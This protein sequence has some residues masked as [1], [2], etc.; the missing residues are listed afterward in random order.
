[1][2]E[3]SIEQSVCRYAKQRGFLVYKFTSPAQRGVPDRLF[4]NKNG[5]TGFIEFKAPGNR[6]TELQM[7]HLNLLRVQG[8]F[9]EW[10]DSVAE[11][12]RLIDELAERT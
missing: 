4:V 12:K 10:C 8:A 6:P 3:S 2:R 7:H 1:M 9:A 5:V 11:G